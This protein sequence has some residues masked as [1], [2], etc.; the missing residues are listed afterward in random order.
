[1]LFNPSSTCAT[2]EPQG[3]S[4]LDSHR[5]KT[6]QRKKSPVLFGPRESGIPAPRASTCFATQYNTFAHTSETVRNK[7]AGVSSFILADFSEAI[8]L[9][10]FNSSGRSAEENALDVRRKTEQGLWG[11]FALFVRTGYVTSSFAFST[12]TAGDPSAPPPVTAVGGNRFESF[13]HGAISRTR[14]A[15]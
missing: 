7:R 12:F 2:D 5:G 10:W 9:M 13:R 11:A 4:E 1:M 15:S 6:Q 8:S 3:Y 14:P